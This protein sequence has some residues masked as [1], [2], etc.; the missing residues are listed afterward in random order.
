MTEK[1]TLREREEKKVSEFFISP[2]GRSTMKWVNFAEKWG[3]NSV[4]L[5]KS[6]PDGDKEITFLLWGTYF[7]GKKEKKRKKFE[8]LMPESGWEK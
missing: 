4:N 5:G 3:Q 1:F 8:S 6:Y 2:T 7:N